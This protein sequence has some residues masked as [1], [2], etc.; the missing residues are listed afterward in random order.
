MKNN[1]TKQRPDQKQL[2]DE[3][4][5]A[6]RC[7]GFNLR[8]AARAVGQ[9]YDAMLEPAGLKGT[10][11]SLLMA[12]SIAGRAPVGR[13]AEALVMDRTTLTRNLRPLI[14]RGLL[15]LVAGTDKRVRLVALTKAGHEALDQARPL[16]ARAQGAIEAGIGPK[17]MDQVLKNLG[18]VTEVALEQKPE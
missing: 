6:G 8:K 9:V 1:A 7:V 14:S 18:R 4:A 15:E 16:W 17:A 3:R 5:I 13:L 2:S 12:A 10:Q 11:F